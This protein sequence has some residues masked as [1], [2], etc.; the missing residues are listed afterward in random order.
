[1]K[2]TNSTNSTPSSTIG[3]T[4]SKRFE[5]ILEAY[6]RAPPDNKQF[7]RPLLVQA[8]VNPN[9]V[10]LNWEAKTKRRTESTTAKRETREPAGMV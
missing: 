4:K 1:M 7:I 3:T 8:A 5:I 10:P 6:D 2:S 9:E